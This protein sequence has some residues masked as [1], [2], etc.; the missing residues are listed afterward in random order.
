MKILITGSREIRQEGLDYAK[1]ITERAWSKGHH[2]IVG[3]AEGVDQQ[4]IKTAWSLAAR[5]TEKARKFIE[6]H[7][8]YEKIKLRGPGANYAHDSTYP[9][10]NEIMV[11]KLDPTEDM[12]IAI[13]DGKSTG[14]KHTML[15]A[16]ARKIEVH[17]RKV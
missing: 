9:Q 3:D 16:K 5:N 17:T 12:V 1:Y 13:W 7:G 14:T 11:N 15:L 6:V 4:V 8:A 10:R 2:L